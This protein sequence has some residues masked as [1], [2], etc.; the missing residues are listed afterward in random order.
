[1]IV[2]HGSRGLLACVAGGGVGASG[3]VVFGSAGVAVDDIGAAVVIT[4]AAGAP[5]GG[6]LAKAA[7]GST[8]HDELDVTHGGLGRQGHG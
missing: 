5:P 8:Q 6:Q 3:A 1:M 4:G 2:L 7:Q